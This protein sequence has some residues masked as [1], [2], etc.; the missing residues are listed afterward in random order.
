MWFNFADFDRTFAAL[1]AMNGAMNGAISGL[2]AARSAPFARTTQAPKVIAK[3]D[4]DAWTVHAELPGVP[5]DAVELTLTG[6]VLRIAARRQPVVAG[7][8]STLHRR[9]RH[10]FEL[11]RSLT[12]PHKV[13]AERVT[14]R[15]HDGIFTVHLPKAAESRPRTIA[16]Q[17]H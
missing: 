1:D 12:L 4:G 3:D 16:V 7:E 11:V 17:T 13:D 9:E 10:G 8:D 6:Q 15:A 2:G 14:A 5:P